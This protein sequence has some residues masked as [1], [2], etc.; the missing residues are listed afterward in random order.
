MSL[1]LTHLGVGV[2]ASVPPRERPRQ[3]PAALYTDPPAPQRLT[4]FDQAQ[5]PM[6]KHLVILDRD[7]EIL[8]ETRVPTADLHVLVFDQKP[9][10]GPA[11]PTLEVEADHHPPIGELVALP[12]CLA[13]VPQ[14]HIGVGVLESYVHPFVGPS[15]HCI[16]HRLQFAP[17]PGQLVHGAVPIWLGADLDGC[18]KLELLRPERVSEPF[19]G[20][21]NELRVAQD[22]IYLGSG[23]GAT[24]LLFLKYLLKGHPR[25]HAV[26]D[27]LEDAL[28]TLGERGGARA[29]EESLPK[30]SSLAHLEF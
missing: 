30:G 26:E 13:P 19:S 14:H 15:P 18:L 27:V 12:E 9:E 8:F 1:P 3:V 11:P 10:P 2:R 5:V 4:P 16:K 6:G 7:D 22:L 20:G 28:L 25:V 21:L 29:T 23:T 24:Y 17:R